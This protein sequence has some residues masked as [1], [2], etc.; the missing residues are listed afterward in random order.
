MRQKSAECVILGCTEICLLI[1]ASC[2]PLPVFD[3]TAIHVETA[4]E[5]TLS[6]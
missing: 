3:T 5:M 2:S 4:L 1:D 6:D